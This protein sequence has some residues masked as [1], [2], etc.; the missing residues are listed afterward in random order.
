[1]LPVMIRAFIISGVVSFA[2]VNPAVAQ[3]PDKNQ[4]EIDKVAGGHYKLGSTFYQAGK[5][6]AARIEFEAAYDLS[7]LCVS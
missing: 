4:G 3:S 6:E 7:T 2:A 1:M 5:Y